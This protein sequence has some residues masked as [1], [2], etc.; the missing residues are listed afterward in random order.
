M[1]VICTLVIYAAAP[2]C[3]WLAA[4]TIVTAWRGTAQGARP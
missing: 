1:T 2:L 4:R 3:I